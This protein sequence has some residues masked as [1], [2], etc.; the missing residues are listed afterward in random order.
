MIGIT[1]TKGKSTTTSLTYEVLKDQ[2]EDVYL[3]GNIGKPVLDEVENYTD[4]TI[5]VIEM[6]S[7]QLEFVRRSPHIAAILNLYQDHLDHDGTVEHYHQNKLNIFKY[8]NDTDYYIYS[9]D[10]PDL[11]K[12]IND[13]PYKGIKYTVR[14]DNVKRYSLLFTWGAAYV[15]K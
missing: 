6:S 14:F 1:G 11:N 7:H 9:D 3:L 13:Y 5:L 10:N 12:K 4:K 8:Q 15:K 2:L